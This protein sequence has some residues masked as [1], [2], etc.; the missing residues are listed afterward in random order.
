MTAEHTSAAPNVHTVVH[1]G[2]SQQPF[3]KHCCKWWQ[4]QWN[5]RQASTGKEKSQE[6]NGEGGM[7]GWGRN[8]WEVK[9]EREGW[10]L[11]AP[12]SK[13][14]QPF[15]RSWKNQ[16]SWFS[17]SPSAFLRPI[18]S[19][20]IFDL[21][22]GFTT[23]LSLQK[24]FFIH[25]GQ[26]STA[27]MSKYSFLS[28]ATLSNLTQAT[29]TKSSHAKTASMIESYWFQCPIEINMHRI[30][31]LCRESGCKWVIWCSLNWN[32]GVSPTKKPFACNF[33]FLPIFM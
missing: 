9:W 11:A 26:I 30:R 32:Y 23:I 33:W 25:M 4:C 22:I 6:R 28:F 13:S 8:G 27:N 5:Y 16:E 14:H 7:S 2:G 3:Q 10:I 18:F 15:P 1:L 20:I 31:E 17:A 24:Y 29:M 21:W 12:F 19:G